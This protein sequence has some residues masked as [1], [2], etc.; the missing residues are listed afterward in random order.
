MRLRKLAVVAFVAII[1]ASCGGSSDE[2]PASST[3]PPTTSAA[4]TSTTAAPTTT[5]EA[6]APDPLRIVITNDDGVGAGGI[7]ALV[8]AI[9]AMDDVEVFVVAPAENASGSSDRMAEETVTYEDATTSGGFSAVAVAG[10]PADS[11][12]VS[13]N[14]LALDPDLVVSGVNSGHNYGPFAQLSGTVGAARTAARNGVP[15]VAVSAGIND[16]EG[17]VLAADLAVDWIE[18]NREAVAAGTLTLD[19]IVSFNV[20]NCTA[21]EVRGLVQTTLAEEFLSEAPFESDCSVEVAEVPG[22]DVGAVAAGY[23]AQTDVPIDF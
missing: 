13:L 7:D 14:E 6:P 10:L 21:G 11:V 5:T 8:A 9:S 22:D 19:T 3:V 12:L 15:A 20:P 23:A 1:A 2:E 18:A 17:Y 16:T 4:V